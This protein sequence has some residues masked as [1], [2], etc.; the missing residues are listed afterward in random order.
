M[1]SMMVPA[2]PTSLLDAFIEAHLIKLVFP[3]TIFALLAVDI[4]KLFKSRPHDDR[5]SQLTIELSYLQKGHCSLGPE[6]E[7]RRGKQCGRQVCLRRKLQF[8]TR[9]GGEE[10]G[11]K[12]CGRHICLRRKSTVY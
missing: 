1:V 5:L 8:R 11:G 10:R 4:W 12:E 9:I 3:Q 6:Y 7:E 2:F